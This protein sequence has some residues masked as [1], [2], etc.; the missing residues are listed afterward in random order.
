MSADATSVLF[1]D[2]GRL[3]WRLEPFRDPDI[4]C[5]GVPTDSV[6]GLLC[7]L[8]TLIT[9]DRAWPDKGV[10][11]AWQMSGGAWMPCL[12]VDEGVFAGDKAERQRQIVMALFDHLT[13]AD[14]PWWNLVHGEPISKTR[15]CPAAISESRRRK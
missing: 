6:L 5:E 14:V 7:A 2:N 12:W 10:R 4:V 11:M 3:L 1:E 13:K 9:F 8:G 15:K